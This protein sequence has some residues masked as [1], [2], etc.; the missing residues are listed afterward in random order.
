MPFKDII[1]VYNENYTKTQELE[2]QSCLMLN[3]GVYTGI[4]CVPGRDKGNYLPARIEKKMKIYL[5]IGT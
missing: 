3:Q 1:P 4:T 2:V 5:P